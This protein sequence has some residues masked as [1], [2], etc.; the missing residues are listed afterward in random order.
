[1]VAGAILVPAYSYY[2]DSRLRDSFV[3]YKL[4]AK[5]PVSSTASIFQL[6]PQVS[7]TDFNVYKEAWRK[8]IWNVHFKQP[9]IQ[10]VRA[11]TPL[12][13]VEGVTEKEGKNLRFLIRRDP[14]GEVSSYLH[15]LPVGAEIELRGP[16]LEYH[17]THDIRQ[18]VFFAGGTGISPALQIAHTMFDAESPAEKELKKARKLHILWANRTREDCAGGISDAPAPALEAPKKAL[19]GFFTKP[20]PKPVVDVSSQTKGIIVQELEALRSKYPGRITVE[21]FVNEE[22]TWIDQAAV[23]K[24]LSR[25]DDK[26]FSTGT[27]TP[28]EQRQVLISGPAG[29]ITYLAGPKEWKNGREEQGDIGKILAHAIATN[30]HNVKVWKI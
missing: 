30:P 27:T 21:Y 4:V 13:P 28:Q 5:E 7:S 14:H 11:Y 18:V 19:A 24:A 15:N 23:I 1:M 8:G 22:D 3:K 10:I 17:L 6:E 16:N 2:E 25:F 26:D 20:I 12:P 9:Q 29:F